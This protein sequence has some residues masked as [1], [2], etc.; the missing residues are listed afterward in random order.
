MHTETVALLQ[1]FK[2]HLQCNTD[3]ELAE[4]L[5]VSPSQI[6]RWKQKGLPKA[7]QSLVQLHLGQMNPTVVELIERLKYRFQCHTDQELAS[8]LGLALSQITSMKYKNMPEY[9]VK[10]LDHLL[11]QLEQS[12]E[13]MNYLERFQ[14]RSCVYFVQSGE[15][16]LIKIGYTNQLKKRVSKMQ[17]DSS[18]T[19]KVLFAMDASPLDEKLLH[20]GLS[21]F[22]VHGEWFQPTEELLE[23]IE[24]QEEK[25]Q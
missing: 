16:G 8:N 6:S 18:K 19:L 17:T 25:Y 7:I 3:R 14:D 15:G 12:L 20:S 22:R 21:E 24:E 9:L 13:E 1:A 11:P 10:I 4:F 2:D 23:Y 5:D